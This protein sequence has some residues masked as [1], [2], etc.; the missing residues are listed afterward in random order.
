MN[1]NRPTALNGINQPEGDIMV[2]VGSRTET[3]IPYFAM[4]VERKDNRA[5]AT[6]D[7]TT[8]T[9]TIGGN[10]YRWLN[11]TPEYR[12][13]WRL[14]QTREFVPPKTAVYCT[15]LLFA[16]DELEQR[17][18]DQF[19]GM[20]IVVRTQMLSQKL[21]DLRASLEKGLLAGGYDLSKASPKS[22]RDVAAAYI[23]KHDEIN[24]MLSE[25]N[26][27]IKQ[28]QDLEKWRHL[29]MSDFT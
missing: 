9:K 27:L 20:S 11:A 2:P 13:A 12:N 23:K 1:V 7:K 22:R 8:L 16:N 15:W 6:D 3:N 21:D 4:P 24:I 5:S 28:Q 14:I 29:S 26:G 18:L 10:T 17:F 19:P 25:L